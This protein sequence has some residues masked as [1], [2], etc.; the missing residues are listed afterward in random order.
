MH[1]ITKAAY[2]LTLN[3]RQEIAVA[4]RIDMSNVKEV[5]LSGKSLIDKV[6]TVKVNLAAVE[7]ADSSCLALLI[8]WIR[9][10]K[11]QHKDIALYNLPHFVADLGRV[12]GLD[13][14]LPV[15]R[16]LKFNN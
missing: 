1:S 10:A 4:G 16:P 13:H 14:I 11:V 15:E 6:A 8:D 5:S 2:Q 3:D 9:S 7:Y 12:C